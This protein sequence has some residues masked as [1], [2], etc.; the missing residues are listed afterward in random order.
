ML[1][2]VDLIAFRVCRTPTV[3][4][5]SHHTADT[6]EARTVHHRWTLIHILAWHGVDRTESQ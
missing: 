3:C 5:Y 4:L 2:I 1:D 6:N